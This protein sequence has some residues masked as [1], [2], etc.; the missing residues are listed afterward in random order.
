MNVAACL[1]E[2]ELNAAYERMR[3]VVD[4]MSATLGPSHPDTLC[5]QANVAITANVM[6]ARHPGNNLTKTLELLSDTIGKDH[7]V[8]TD[9]KEGRLIHR[10]LDPHPW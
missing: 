10:I 6:G 7:P 2:V 4:L 3:H 1:A 5:C 8:V 9:L